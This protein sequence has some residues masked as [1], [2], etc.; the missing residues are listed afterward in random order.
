[1]SKIK[2]MYVCLYEIRK[3][4]TKTN[5]RL[6]KIPEGRHQG[7]LIAIIQEPVATVNLLRR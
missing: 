2:C 6:S 5:S 7:A 3:S 1:M 4:L